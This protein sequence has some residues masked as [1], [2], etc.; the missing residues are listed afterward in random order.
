MRFIL[1]SLALS[2]VSASLSLTV[3]PA[4]QSHEG[5]NTGHY[6]IVQADVPRASLPKVEL[7]AVSNFANAKASF[8]CSKGL[9][10]LL[11][12]LNGQACS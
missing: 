5:A 12:A 6:Y 3:V 1:L 4:P 2:A 10:V 11:A 8:D 9:T 7:P